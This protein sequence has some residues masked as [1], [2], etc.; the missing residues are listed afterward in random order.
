MNI[1][2]KVEYI[3]SRKAEISGAQ[4]LIARLDETL[5]A[6]SYSPARE[7]E[8]ASEYIV[9]AMGELNALTE[10]LSEELSV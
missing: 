8:I 6:L 4:R 9:K 7:Q 1:E 3:S 10:R 5:K 2:D